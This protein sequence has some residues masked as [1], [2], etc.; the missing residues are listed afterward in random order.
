MKKRNKL[1]LQIL[2][3]RRMAGLSQEELA[4]KLNCTNRTIQIWERG[5]VVPSLKKIA[6]LAKILGKEI[7]FFLPP[8]VSDEVEKIEVFLPLDIASKIRKSAKKEHLSVS[9]F[10]RQK[11]E[12]IFK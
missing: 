10:A 8:D 7:S 1:G 12:D 4:Q 2:M 11:L 3:A 5:D 6:L 9:D